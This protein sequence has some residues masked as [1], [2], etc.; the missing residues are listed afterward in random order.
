MAT[1]TK[2]LLSG[3][4]NGEAISVADT[5]TTIHTA[6]STSGELDEV[7]IYAHNT[8]TA[9]V[10]LTIE[11]DGTTGVNV[12]KQTIPNDAGLV[13]VVPGLI[14]GGAASLDITALAGTT[15]VIGI[16]GYVNRIA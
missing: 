7:W 10:E 3:S 9:A 16:T 13:L 14:I 15:S 1:F 11:W 6:T 5:S 12:I 8:H 4:T 2:E